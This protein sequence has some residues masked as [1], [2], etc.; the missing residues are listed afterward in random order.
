MEENT[1]LNYCVIFTSKACFSQK[2]SHIPEKKVIINET[3]S[4]C[5]S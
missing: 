4:T 3:Y 2:S 1:S 5:I